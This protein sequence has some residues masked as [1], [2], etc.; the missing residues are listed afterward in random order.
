MAYP[1]YTQR[2][3]RGFARG[4]LWR[5]ELLEPGIEEALRRDL[6]AAICGRDDV[7]VRR[8]PA[9]A[10][11]STC[12]IAGA[13]L[14]TS[15]PEI[16]LLESGNARRD[17]FSLGHEFGHFLIDR[18]TVLADLLFREPDHGVALEEEICNSFAAML[19]I[20]GEVIQAALDGHAATAA[21]VWRLYDHTNASR[22]ACSIAATF[23]LP[24]HGYILIAER[25]SNAGDAVTVF[26]AF[27]EAM[28]R[29]A[30]GHVQAGELFAEAFTHRRAYGRVV[31]IRADGT[32]TEEL[33]AEVLATDS[34]AVGV[35]VLVTHRAGKHSEA[36]AEARCSAAG[37]AYGP[38]PLLCDG[39]N[40]PNCAVCM[41]CA[42]GPASAGRA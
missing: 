11:A 23:H 16:V 34:I 37:H 18:D 6:V 14:R 21:T 25:D 1:R 36:G 15:P 7:T 39:C 30:V 28:P 32:P 24:G 4:L 9:R 2:A 3:I 35:F 26:A 41:E 38:S 10:R 29:L 27:S 8:E 5:R 40:A 17:L 31:L 42:C 19:L 13:F 20:S 22:E 12:S 33:D